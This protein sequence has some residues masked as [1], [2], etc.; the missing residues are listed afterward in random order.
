MKNIPIKDD[1]KYLGIHISKK[2]SLR[3]EFNFLP[4][5]KIAKLIFNNWLQRYLS[6]LGRVL[7]I[8]AEGLSHFIYPSFSLFVHDNTCKQ[9]NNL[10]FK[11]FL[12]L[13][14]KLSVVR[15]LMEV[16][17]CLIFLYLYYTFK[18]NWVKN[19]VSSPDSIWYFIPHNIYKNVGGL[20]FLLTC[21]F[22]PSKLPI[23]LSKFHEQ[24][25][26]AWKLCFVHN[27]SP[28]KVK[29]WNNESIL[30]KNKSIFLKNWH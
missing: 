19:C 2:I 4:K 6:F 24:A 27:F 15:K 3:Q 29:I 5:I 21:N 8:K 22:S 28:R 17:T 20:T 1:V 7:L 9:I 30:V 16:L 18:V 14:N 23:K 11:F 10:L 25:L 13:S 26:L 12:F